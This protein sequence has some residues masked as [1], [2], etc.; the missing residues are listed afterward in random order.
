MACFILGSKQK[1]ST[2]KQDKQESI[3]KHSPSESKNKLVP[4]EVTVT[5]MRSRR[6]SRRPSD[7]WVVKSQESKYF[8]LNDI[9]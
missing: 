8:F 3:K 1:K 5:V 6:I 9:L 7:W 4:E 2:K